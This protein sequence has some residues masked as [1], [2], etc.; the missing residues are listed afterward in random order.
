MYYR[1][2]DGYVL[3]GW[4]GLPYAIES[5]TILNTNSGSRMLHYTIN[6]KP[7]FL[8]AEQYELVRSFDGET[9]VD[10]NKLTALQKELLDRS[11]K[12]NIISVS[13]QPLS[14]LSQFQRYI[15]YP[16]MYVK[17]LYGRSPVNA[18]IAADI[19]SF[20]R[21]MAYIRSFR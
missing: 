5:C 4:K 14:K 6:R 1:L 12:E 2:N 21:R 20:L 13:K 9:P 8:N 16:A 17:R 3:R 18:T 11:L 10:E 15:Y 7:Y 19:A